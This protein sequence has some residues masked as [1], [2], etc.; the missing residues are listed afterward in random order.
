MKVGLVQRD[1][2]DHPHS[3][4]LLV[5]WAL[6]PESSLAHNVKKDDDG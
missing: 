5:G 1:Y 6:V 2:E 3:D 4:L